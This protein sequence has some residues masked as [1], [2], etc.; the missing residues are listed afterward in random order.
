MP[1]FQLTERSRI[2][3]FPQRGSYDRATIYRILDE[4]LV[5]HIGFVEDDEPLV[6]PMNYARDGDRLLLH[7]AHNSRLVRTLAA[8][9]PI[10]ITVTL[11]DGLVVAERAAHHSMNYRSVMVFGR[12][13]EIT[14]EEEKAA[15]LRA[16]N[17]HFLPGHGDYALPPTAAEIRGVAVLEIPLNEASAKVR[18]GPPIAAAQSEVDSEQ[19]SGEI[20]LRL[21]AQHRQLLPPLKRGHS[22][23]SKRGHST[24]SK[25]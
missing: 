18:S 3:Q 11:I 23:F 21:T 20:P 15:A 12:A 6:I 8:G 16:F 9:V 19:W 5:C 7:G 13:A 1:E 4:G 10:C 22:T 2:R 17:E 14:D 24:F 25:K